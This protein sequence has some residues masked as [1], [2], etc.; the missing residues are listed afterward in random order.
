MTLPKFLPC[1]CCGADVCW[2]WDV[3]VD[4]RPGEV[5]VFDSPYIHEAFV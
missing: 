5:G 3:R 1:P 4:Y 2:G